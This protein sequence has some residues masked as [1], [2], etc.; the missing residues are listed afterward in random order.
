MVGE[1]G[2]AGVRAC[3]SLPGYGMGEIHIFMETATCVAVRGCARQWRKSPM[4]GGEK[5][6]GRLRLV[7]VSTCIRMLAA[8]SLAPWTVSACHQ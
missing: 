8:G 1:K 2:A 6:I 5:G 7:T 3:P 4:A